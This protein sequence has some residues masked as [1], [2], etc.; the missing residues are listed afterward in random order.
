MPSTKPLA[1]PTSSSGSPN[2]PTSAPTQ[3]LSPIH[4][5]TDQVQQ[6]L[7]ILKEGQGTSNSSTKA[8]TSKEKDDKAKP[9]IRA[10][11]PDIKKV[12]QV[13]AQLFLMGFQQADQLS[14]LVG[15]SQPTSSR[16][17]SHWRRVR[18][19]MINIW[20]TSGSFESDLVS[21]LP[22]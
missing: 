13:Y 16:L 5:T 1:K 15:T 12:C 20:S 19:K 10:S 4:V 21:L 22:I 14:L 7:D 6:L 11:K 8:S 18:T 3:P 9:R 2:S 17:R